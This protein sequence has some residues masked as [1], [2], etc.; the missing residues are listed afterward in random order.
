MIC[1][2]FVTYDYGY[3][4]NMRSNSVAT[5]QTDPALYMIRKIFYSVRS[6]IARRNIP[7]SEIRRRNITLNKERQTKDIDVS[8]YER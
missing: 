7:Y 4:Q 6:K 3:Q 8:V 2:R 5:V 1:I